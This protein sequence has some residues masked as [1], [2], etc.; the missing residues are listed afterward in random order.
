MEQS[1]SWEANGFS[2]SQEI[3]HS[4]WSPAVHYRIHSILPL[5][6]I[7]SQLNPVRDFSF[8]FFKIHFNIVPIDA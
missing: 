4:L 5:V 6:P 1:P 2:P 8:H 3:P 7:L